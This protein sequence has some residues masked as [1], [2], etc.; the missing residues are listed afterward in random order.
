MSCFFERKNEPSNFTE[1]ANLLFRHL[2]G[3]RKDGVIHFDMIDIES[4]H[5]KITTVELNDS[6]KERELAEI[7]L[8]DNLKNIRRRH[9]VKNPTLDFKEAVGVTMMI[10]FLDQG[11]K[12]SYLMVSMGG[13]KETFLFTGFPGFGNDPDKY[14]EFFYSQV[15]YLNPLYGYVDAALISGKQRLPEFYFGWMSFFS[16]TISLPPIPEDYEIQELPVRGKIV[17]TT[18]EFFDAKNNI[19]HYNKAMKLVELFREY[20]VVRPE[21]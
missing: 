10:K 9:K 2:N 21:I 13:E 1:I 18:R 20:S 3:L 17:I 12:V 15:E 11:K 16:N 6:E 4:L 19:E 5:F 7:L 8:K 14:F